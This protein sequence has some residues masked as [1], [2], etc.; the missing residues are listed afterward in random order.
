MLDERPKPMHGLFPAK[1]KEDPEEEDF[2]KENEEKKID[3]PEE[4]NR[5]VNKVIDEIFEAYD[6]DNSGELCKDEVK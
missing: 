3:D 6:D 1:K 4:Q 5:V 2:I